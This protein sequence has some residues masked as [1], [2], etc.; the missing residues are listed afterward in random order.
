MQII[1]LTN[2]LVLNT[3]VYILSYIILLYFNAALS[4][5]FHRIL[6]LSLFYFMI[7]DYCILAENN[8]TTASGDHNSEQLLIQQ[9][10]LLMVLK[11]TLVQPYSINSI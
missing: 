10:Y 9:K 6:F 1:C 7:K 4:C 3:V 11:K 8:P 2:L 5:Q